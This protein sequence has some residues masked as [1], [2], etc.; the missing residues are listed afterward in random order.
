MKTPAYAIPIALGLALLAGLASGCEKG[1][2]DEGSAIERQILQQIG[3]LQD[4]VDELKDAVADL[5]TQP[6]QPAQPTRAPSPARPTTARVPVQTAGFPALGPKDAPVTIVE[7]TDYQCPFC[8]RHFAQ[9]LPQIKTAYVDTGKVR[10]VVVD[11]PLPGHRYALPAAEAA[12]CAGDQGKFWEMHDYLFNNQHLIKP[13][14]LPGFAKTLGL[15]EKTFSA[16]MAAN[17]HEPQIQSGGRMAAAAGATG[18]P[19]FV[20]GKTTPDGAVSGELIVGAKAYA[21]FKDR[22]DQLLA[23]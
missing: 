3:A 1:G 18:T 21:L 19:S 22:L 9:T 5:K 8:R 11:N 6:A 20:V 12:H 4:D 23:N 14:A 13:E 2:G 7:F 10:Y 17:R 15:D 16:C